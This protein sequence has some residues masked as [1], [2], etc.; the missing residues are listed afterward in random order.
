MSEL[1]QKNEILHDKVS[2]KYNYKHIEIYNDIEQNRLTKLINSILVLINKNNIEALDYWS[3]TWNL[4]WHFLSKWCSSF[5]LDISQKSLDVLKNKFFNYQNKLNIIK[6]EWYDIP[7]E[8]DK[9]DL[10]GIYSVLHHVPDYIYALEDIY[11]VI[12]KWWYLLIDHEANNNYWNPDNYL[13]EYNKLSNDFFKKLKNI[14]ISWELFEY[15]F[16]K[17][18]FIRKFVNDRYRAEWDIH[19]FKDDHIEWDLVKEKLKNLWFEIVEENDYLL[20]NIN[21]SIEE[22]EKYNKKTSNT[23]YIIAKKL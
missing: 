19:V 3:W 6:F 20:Y 11:R 16:W 13:L 21:V 10:V 14:F 2:K 1:I 5:A 12:K 7:I 9:F 22:Y 18:I 15:W 4:T 23:K 8:N 17:S